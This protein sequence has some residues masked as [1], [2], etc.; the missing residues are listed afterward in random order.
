[1]SVQLE[2]IKFNHD[3]ASA[4]HDALNLRRN[5]TEFVI[6]PEWQRGLSI[7]PEDSPA[8]YALAETRGNTITIQAQFR[9]TDPGLQGVQIRAIDPLLPLGNAGCLGI[10]W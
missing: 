10:L 2:A 5:A 8:A 7:K 4:T 1:M 3:S 6:V 9:R